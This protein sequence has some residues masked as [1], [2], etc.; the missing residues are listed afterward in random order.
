M[1]K[2][3][4]WWFDLQKA[5]CYLCGERSTV[6]QYISSQWLWWTLTLVIMVVAD[7]DAACYWICSRESGGLVCV[8]VSFVVVEY[9]N[10]CE[11][12]RWP[13]LL[14]IWAGG[15]FCCSL[16][17]SRYPSKWYPTS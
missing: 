15:R 17:E 8:V 3:Q 14:E 13:A 10:D 16:Y 2:F 9:A 1:L 12:P 6:Y 4:M 11:R 7:V 5:F